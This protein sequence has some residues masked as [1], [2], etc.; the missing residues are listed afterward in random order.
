MAVSA[1]DNLLRVYESYLGQRGYHTARIPETTTMTPDLE[2]SGHGGTFL[3]EFKSPGL[4]L[5]PALGL[6][7]FTTTNSK[8]LHFIHTAIK[9][10]RAFDQSH[11]SPW[12]ITFASVNFQLH[13]H[14]LFEA[15]QGGCVAEGKVI[16]DWTQAEVF[17]RWTEDRYVADLY[18]W[19]Q[20]NDQDRQPYQASFFTN[21][22]S[23]HRQLVT[24]L[25]AGLRAAPL[26]SADNNW[27][28]V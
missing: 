14:T 17:R 27:L 12:V 13:W 19:L 8:L 22:R 26:S 24:E 11:C 1:H 21:S 2:V 25:V 18:L 4:Q 3:S 10:F 28:L 5:D 16:A 23:P 6:Y 20:V 15:M 9:Q 7:K